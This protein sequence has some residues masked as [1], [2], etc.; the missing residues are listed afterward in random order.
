[1]LIII[2]LCSGNAI[3]VYG[4]LSKGSL[5]RTNYSLDDGSPFTYSINDMWSNADMGVDVLYEAPFYESPLLDYGPHKLNVTV[6]R[7]LSTDNKSYVLEFLTINVNNDANPYLVIVDDMHPAIQYDG[8]WVHGRA[9]E[10]YNETITRAKTSGCSAKF[11]F[12]GDSI[13]VYGSIRTNGDS[14]VAKFRI[15]NGLDGYYSLNTGGGVRPKTRLYYREGLGIGN[16]TLQIDALTSSQL[17]LDYFIYTTPTSDKP[18][19]TTPISNKHLRAALVGE[20]ISSLAGMV[21]YAFLIFLFYR[22]RNRNRKQGAKQKV[23]RFS[24]LKFLDS[25]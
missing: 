13:D 14:P 5:H 22:Y 8:D 23:V 15:D 4:T 9:A 24:L 7:Y 17:W 3:G 18:I 11:T 16:H 20:I 19:E 10:G 25:K 21:P 6:D 1:L 12:Y 2:F